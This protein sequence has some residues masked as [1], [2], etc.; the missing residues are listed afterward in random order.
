MKK[1]LLIAAGV[2]VGI[3]VAFYLV[4]LVTGWL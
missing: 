1:S 2:L 3:V 4:V